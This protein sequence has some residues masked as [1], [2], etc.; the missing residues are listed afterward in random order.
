VTVVVV[1]GSL[2]GTDCVVRFAAVVFAEFSGAEKRVVFAS[3]VPFASPI[4]PLEVT[5]TFQGEDLP[6]GEDSIC[7]GAAKVEEADVDTFAGA[8]NASVRQT[9][10]PLSI[11]SHISELDGSPAS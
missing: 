7:I 6:V 9:P 2:E 1:S 3:C 4:V 8:I 11:C 10:S 5:T